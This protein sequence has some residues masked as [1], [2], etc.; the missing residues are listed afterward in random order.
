MG[1]VA[2]D[3]PL[4]AFACQLNLERSKVRLVLEVFFKEFLRVCV[5]PLD[6]RRKVLADC[7]W[8]NRLVCES[9]V[10][11]VKFRFRLAL[12]DEAVFSQRIVEFPCVC[13]NRL[14]ACG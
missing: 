13:K 12:Y 10:L 7:L 5:R 14:A 11:C 3:A 9:R 8:L 2:V 1:N 6:C 4:V